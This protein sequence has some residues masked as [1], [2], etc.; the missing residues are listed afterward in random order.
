MRLQVH[1]TNKRGNAVSTTRSMLSALRKDYAKQMAITQSGAPKKSRCTKTKQAFKYTRQPCD[2]RFTQKT[3]PGPSGM[4]I[5]S[6]AVSTTLPPIRGA[7]KTMQNKGRSRPSRDAWPTPSAC[8]QRVNSRC[9]C[10][11]FISA[12]AFLSAVSFWPDNFC[13]PSCC[14]L[15]VAIGCTLPSQLET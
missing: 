1:Q 8:L 6:N 2:S 15:A 13:H 4:Y 9:Q 5:R 12:L 3:N 7:S 11:F 10:L 14:K